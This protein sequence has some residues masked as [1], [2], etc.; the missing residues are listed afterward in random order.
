M[1]DFRSCDLAIKIAMLKSGEDVIAQMKEIVH[2]D[3]G[4]TYG[5]TFE[6]PYIVKLVDNTNLL[7]EDTE[8]KTSLSYSIRYY[9]WAPLSK[10][11]TF[12]VDKNWVVTIYEPQDQVKNSY[13]ENSGAEN[14][15]SA[16]ET[17]HE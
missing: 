9:P 4:E 11:K 13:L 2:T 10:D 3:T 17:D 5:Y 15:S 6:N 12:Y 7:L 14:E 16:S 8:E 1:I